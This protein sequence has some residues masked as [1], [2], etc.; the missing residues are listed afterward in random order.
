M[1]NNN[2]HVLFIIEI[3]SYGGAT[4]ALIELS[5]NLYLKGV[6]ISLAS[7]ND[8]D[9]NRPYLQFF[10]DLYPNIKP[11]KLASLIKEKPEIDVVHWWRTHAR[12]N[13]N[14]FLK[15]LKRKVK[16]ITTIVQ[17]PREYRYGL[18]INEIE[19]SDKIL[20][21]TKTSFEHW[22]YSFLSDSDKQM[23]Y[24]G[25][26]ISNIPAPKINYG[27]GSHFLLGRGSSLN[28][29]VNEAIE[30]FS[31]LDIK[32]KKFLIAGGNIEDKNYNRLKLLINKLNLI[33]DVNLVG[34]L[35]SEPW[36]KFIKKLDVFFYHLPKNSYS[37]IDRAIRD[38]MLCGVPVVLFGP[39]APKELIENGKSGFIANN[40]DE[41]VSYTEKL[42]NSIELREEIGKSGRIR[43]LNEFNIQK[44]TEQYIRLYKKINIDSKI[45]YKVRN[46]NLFWKTIYT[47]SYCKHLLRSI[48]KK[49]L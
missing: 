43:I 5:R 25:T 1:V 23:I 29:C 11:E 14:V 15:N 27:I 16:I 7:F 31:K 38:A 2:I 41:F 40:L 35:N 42:Y 6:K 22:K 12:K 13:I 32:N 24:V 37:G 3:I 44:S 18:S 47:G 28:K 26:D 39:S 30:V 8:F 46:M 4:K 17:L 48:L 45:K 21:T 9:V 49:M 19:Y 36:Y 20:L 34:Q 10:N 33:D